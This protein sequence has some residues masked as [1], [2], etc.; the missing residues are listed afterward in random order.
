VKLLAFR[1]YFTYVGAL[2]ILLTSWLT[3][4]FAQTRVYIDI[5]QVGGYLLPIAL[6]KLLGEIDD[7]ELGQG[8]RAV[9]LAARPGEFGTL[10]YHRR[11]HVYRCV[12]TDA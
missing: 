10:S 3:L 6:P 4:V 1:Q 7:P 9:L 2:S 8:L 5:D 12:S 11:R